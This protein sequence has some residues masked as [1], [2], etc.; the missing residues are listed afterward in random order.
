MR[1]DGT[2]SRYDGCS[3][4]ERATGSLETELKEL[5]DRIAADPLRFQQVRDELRRRRA[6]EDEQ[7]TP[8]TAEQKRAVDAES[9][10]NLDKNLIL[11]ITAMEAEQARLVIEASMAKMAQ[12]DAEERLELVVKHAMA[13]TLAAYLDRFAR[14][15]PPTDN[16]DTRGDKT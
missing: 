7:P 13:G 6:A 4:A 1:D 14:K 8:L 15:D 16:L 2:W 3:D 11:K 9:A 10:A 5:S 12:R